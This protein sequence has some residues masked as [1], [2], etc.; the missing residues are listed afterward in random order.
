MVFVFFGALYPGKG[1][2]STVI[3]TMVDVSAV[4][5]VV[6]GGGGGRALLVKF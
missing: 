5:V 1:R 6:V 3:W 4:V 2:T